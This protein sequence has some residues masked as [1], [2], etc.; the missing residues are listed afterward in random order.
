MSVKKKPRTIRTIR[1]MK[2]TNQMKKSNIAKIFACSTLLALCSTTM[3]QQT[4]QQASQSQPEGK[5]I[6][7]LFGDFHSGLTDATANDLGFNLER[8]YLGYQYNFDNQWSTKVVFDMGKSD[9]V[10]DLQRIGYL[11][12]AYATYNNGKFSMNAGLASTEQFNTQEKFWGYRYL[13]KS[14]QDQYKWGSSAD[15]GVSAKYKFTNWLSADLNIFNGEGYKKVQLDDQLLYGVGLTLNPV[16]GFTLRAYGEAKTANNAVA[17]Q[18][19]A[20]FAGYKQD[21]FSIG[22]E[23]NMQ[24]NNKNVENRDLKGLSVYATGKISK[25]FE[26]FGRYDQG[27]SSAAEGD[28]WSYAQNGQTALL[29]LQYK[30]NNLVSIAPNVRWN[31]QEGATKS[32]FYGYLSAKVNL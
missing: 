10:N 17:Q 20:L 7:T 24:M 11:K 1:K 4:T 31:K 27:T 6:I 8:A 25:S 13:Y 16:K 3:A 21:Y 19:V 26:L 18:A 9:D 23:Y 2:K 29:G 14:F 28:N 30:V 12:N 22:I 15:L 5:P 32:N